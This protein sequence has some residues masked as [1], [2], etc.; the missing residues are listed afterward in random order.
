MSNPPYLC[1]RLIR[2]RYRRISDHSK[3]SIDDIDLYSS[4]KALG[5]SRHLYTAFIYPHPCATSVFIRTDP[6]PV[7]PITT[8]TPLYNARYELGTLRSKET[9]SRTD[10]II[11]RR[12]PSAPGSAASQSNQCASKR[13]ATPFGTVVTVASRYY[14]HALLRPGS[15]HTLWYVVIRFL[16]YGT[17]PYGPMQHAGV[18][19][20]ILHQAAHDDDV[21]AGY[22]D[23]DTLKG[24]RYGRFTWAWGVR[25]GAQRHTERPDDADVELCN[26]LGYMMLLPS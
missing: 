6:T 23:W 17:S 4:T 3:Q 16:C 25:Y 14:S 8:S 15:L 13:I 21:A 5:R 11:V 10:R 26:N 20:L 2:P 24:W 18:G 19:G 12:P 22:G 7:F 9:K 1:S